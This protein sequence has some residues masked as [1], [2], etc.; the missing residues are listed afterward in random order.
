MSKILRD[1]EI[2]KEKHRFIQ[3]VIEGVI[4]LGGVK[5]RVVVEKLVELQ[6]TPFKKFTKVNSTKVNIEENELL[7]NEVN[8]NQDDLDG[9]AYIEKNLK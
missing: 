4:R 3:A 6:F 2:L 5:R 9:D 7:A 8:E 1:V